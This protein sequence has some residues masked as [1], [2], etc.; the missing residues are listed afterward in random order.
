MSR[1]TR[2][3]LRQAVL[4]E[5]ATIRGEQIPISLAEAEF[6]QRCTL[7]EWLPHRPSWPDFLVQTEHGLIGVEVKD[8]DMVSPEQAA[9]FDLLE[10]LGLPVYLWRRG[11]D[12]LTRWNASLSLKSPSATGDTP[13]ARGSDPKRGRGTAPTPWA[14]DQGKAPRTARSEA[15]SGERTRTQAVSPPRQSSRNQRVR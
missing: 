12:Q 13:S 8:R 5:Q 6:K 4:R 7:R 3:W 15:I 11:D 9:T 14:P 2:R 10:T 1:K